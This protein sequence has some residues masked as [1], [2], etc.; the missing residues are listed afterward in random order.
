MSRTKI[1]SLIWTCGRRHG[2]LTIIFFDLWNKLLMKL[3]PWEAMRCD[4]FGLS[5]LITFELDILSN[6]FEKSGQLFTCPRMI[7]DKAEKNKNYH[8]PLIEI[9]DVFYFEFFDLPVTRNGV[10]CFLFFFGSLFCFIHQH[11]SDNYVY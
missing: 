9:K 5:K 6:K 10:Y 11:P 4:H 8:L 2:I 7:I 1:P 3:F